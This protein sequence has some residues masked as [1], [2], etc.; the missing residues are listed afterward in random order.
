MQDEQDKACLEMKEEL[1]IRVSEIKLKIIG[2]RLQIGREI[3]ITKAKKSSQSVEDNYISSW[4][5]YKN[6]C[7]LRPV[8]QAG[9]SNLFN[10]QE[11]LAADFA[12]LLIAHSPENI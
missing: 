7:F 5:Y 6:L 9:K 8:M 1:E 2:L 12:K 10:R 4:M 11:R 3:V